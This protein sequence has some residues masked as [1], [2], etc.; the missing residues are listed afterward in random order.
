MTNFR[1]NFSKVLLLAN[2]N[3]TFENDNQ[4]R[5]ELIPMKVKELYLNTNLIWFLNFLEEDLDSL[6]KY[7]VSVKIE[8]HY[9]FIITLCTLAEK[10]QELQETKDFFL[11]ALNVIVPGFTFERQLKIDSI[12]VDEKLFDLIVE[13]VNKIMSK[14]EKIKVVDGDDEMTRRMKEMQKK[15]QEIKSKGKK[16][17]ENSTSFEDMFAALLY[18]FPQYKLQDLFELNIYTFYYLFKYVGKIAN[19]EVSKIAAG[20][21]LAKKH[22]YFIE[23]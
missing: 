11:K 23:K 13:V 20:N 3:I 16:M 10:Y 1:H 15:I 2:E 4:E 6:Q 18:E 14:K 9:H 17:N 7:L 19:Y 8:S 21:G 22:K 12:S 5:F